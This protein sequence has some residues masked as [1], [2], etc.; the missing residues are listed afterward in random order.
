MEA[1]VVVDASGNITSVD[2]TNYDSG[3]TNEFEYEFNPGA[4]YSSPNSPKV[5][6]VGLMSICQVDGRAGWEEWTVVDAAM[7]LLAKEE[8]DTSQ[9]EREAARIWARIM[10]SMAN[11]DAGQS[12][13]ITDVSFNSGMWPYSSSYPRRY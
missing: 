1:T 5:E 11:R 3:Y 2:V 13:R 9:L 6:N 4:L 12:K 10:K 7:K 8:S